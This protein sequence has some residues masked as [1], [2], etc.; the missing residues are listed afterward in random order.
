LSLWGLSSDVVQ[1]KI[2]LNRMLKEAKGSGRD[3]EP[4]KQK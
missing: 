3:T 4:K 1:R 2:Q